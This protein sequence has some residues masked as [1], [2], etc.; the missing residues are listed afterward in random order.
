MVGIVSQVTLANIVGISNLKAFP[1]RFGQ[2]Q[3]GP[4]KVHS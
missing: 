3:P 2:K 1:V 4:I